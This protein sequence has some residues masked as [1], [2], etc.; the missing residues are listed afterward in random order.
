VHLGEVEDD[1]FTTGDGSAED[2]PEPR[3]IG[4]GLGSVLVWRDADLPLPESLWDHAQPAAGGGEVL[5]TPA[6]T[7]LRFTRNGHT[8]VVAGLVTEQRLA[9]AVP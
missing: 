1:V 6:G 3:R 2:V 7:V 5:E 4:T 8:Y 9:E